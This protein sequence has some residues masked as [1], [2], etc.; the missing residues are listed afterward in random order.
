MPPSEFL[1]SYQNIQ[2]TAGGRRGIYA[3]KVTADSSSVIII[4]VIVTIFLHRKTTSDQTCN[5]MLRNEY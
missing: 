4:L 3:Y 1:G 2:K 5:T